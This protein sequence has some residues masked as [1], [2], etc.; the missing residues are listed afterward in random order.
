MISRMWVLLAVML[1]VLSVFFGRLM[2]LQ[3]A[4]A[5]AFGELS[6]RNFMEERRISPLRGHIL[7]S[8]GAVLADNRVAYDL[9]YWGGEVAN[10]SRLRVLLGLEGEPRPP[11]LDLPEEERQG[12]VLAWNIPDH[13][14]TAVGERVAGQ[15]NLYLRQR[16]ERVYPTNLAAQVVG[17]TTAAD[18]ERFPGYAHEEVAG[19]MGI[20]AGFE[21]ELFGTPGVRRV[22]LDNRR[23]ILRSEVLLAA[24]PGEDV[25]LTINSTVQRAAE[26]ALEGALRYVNTDRERVDL[27]FAEEVR[28]ALIALDP[29]TGAILAMASV[30]SFDQN[31]FT[32]RP[33]DQEVVEPI[34]QD[35]ESLPLSNRAVEAYAPASTFKVVTSSALLEYGYVGPNTRFPCSTQFSLAGITWENWATNDR[36]LYSIREAIADSCN[37]YFWYAVAST[38]GALRGWA[39]FIEDLVLRARELGYGE[40]VD[41]GLGEE[42]EGRIPDL[43][44]AREQYRYGWLPGFTFNTVIG[45]GDVL[46]TPLQVAR[47]VATVAMSGRQFAPHLVAKVGDR[48]IPPESR[49]IPGRYW[50]TLREGMR[51]MFTDFPMQALLG[52]GVFPVDVA[53]KTG[54]AQTP[55]GEDYTH[56]W[57][58]GYG[59]VDDPEL[60]VVVFIEH[61]GSSSRVSVPVAR[62][63]MAAFWGVE[64]P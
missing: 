34:L 27:P 55:R 7:T 60:A 39:P 57:F 43:A 10:W 28:G 38:P 63:F 56:A 42:K 49:Q 1:T 44:W 41:V 32:R 11:N 64:L 18:P 12:A 29:R 54:T 59:P 17:Y 37:T 24:L 20:E 35:R 21:S 61:G 25:T 3:L 33:I 62:D 9:M 51:M 53:G 23:T 58:M 30:P 14:I 52:P 36:G 16:I 15:S 48:V 45:Q 22:E 8:D 47:L 46:A 19:V 4:R 26:E 2:Y 31:L 13:L 5:E 6:I 50:D 40:V